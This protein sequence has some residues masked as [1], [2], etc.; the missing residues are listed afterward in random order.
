[1][2]RSFIKTTGTI[3][4]GMA[5]VGF[6]FVQIAPVFTGARDP[7]KPKAHNIADSY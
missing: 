2:T 5:L 7:N 3:L 1:M 4:L 6:L